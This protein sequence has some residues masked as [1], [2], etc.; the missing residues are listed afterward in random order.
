[1]PR[2]PEV[3]AAVSL[4]KLAKCPSGIHGLDTITGD[5]LPRGRPWLVCGG[6]DSGK[7]LFVVEFLV[8]G[9]QEHDEPAVFMCFEE[10]TKNWAQN[11][12]PLRQ[13][14]RLHTAIDTGPVEALPAT[15]SNRQILGLHLRRLFA[16]LKEKGVTTIIAGEKCRFASL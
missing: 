8:R 12:G 3:V 11:V 13:F 7:T 5:G 1:M 15:L 6:S 4:P 10:R 16:W 14:G 2:H 9:N